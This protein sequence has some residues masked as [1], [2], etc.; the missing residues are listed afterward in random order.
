M[1][2]RISKWFIIGFNI[3]PIVGVAF[4]GWIPFDMFW[5]FWVETLII[6]FF[7]AWRIL[8][9]QGNGSEVPFQEGIKRWNMVRAMRYMIARVLIFLFYSIFI[10]VF[11]GFL[12]SK[13]T[14]GGFIKTLAFANPLFNL[15][16]IVVAI[17]QSFYLIK[18]F[19]MSRAYFY[20]SPD[21]Y[22]DVFDARQIVIHIAIVIGAVGT[23]FL[24][25][26]TAQHNF[27]AI[28][29]MSILCIAK[30]VYELF[31]VNKPDAQT[32][33]ANGNTPS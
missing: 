25:D 12:G 6:G 2:A 29:M 10:V 27:G 32:Y 20:A 9:S 22:A 13:G 3:I 21:S 18:Y 11:I 31:F 17:S 28:F 14:D 15:A 1:E 4:Y 5:L 8:F 19:F 23:A 16:L 30:C 7:N 33:I 26:D 24:F